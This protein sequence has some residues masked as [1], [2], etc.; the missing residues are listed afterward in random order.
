MGG[1]KLEGRPKGDQ[2]KHLWG[3]IMSYIKAK[4]KTKWLKVRWMVEVGPMMWVSSTREGKIQEGKTLAKQHN[5]WK[6][7]NAKKYPISGWP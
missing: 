7:A 4:W 3:Y 5:A 6:W 2:V 1:E